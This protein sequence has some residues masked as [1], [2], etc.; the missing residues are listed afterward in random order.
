MALNE[1]IEGEGAIMA[2][3]PLAH[4]HAA[5][6]VPKGEGQKCESMKGVKIQYGYL[7]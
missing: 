2:R 5:A 1:K 7:I 4:L 6:Q 3:S